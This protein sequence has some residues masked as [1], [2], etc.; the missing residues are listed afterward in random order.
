MS[1]PGTAGALTSACKP[2]P[3]LEPLFVILSLH[4]CPHLHPRNCQYRCLHLLQP[5]LSLS[6]A[7]ENLAWNQSNLPWEW[8]GAHTAVTCKLEIPTAVIMPNITRNR[9]PMTGVGMLASIAPAFPKTPLRSMAQAPAMITMRLPT[10]VGGRAGSDA[11]VSA[12]LSGKACNQSTRREVW[13]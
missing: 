8:K 1:S 3:N 5:S 4:K 2:C 11:P 6:Q 10:W 12:D 13:F 7:G 9:P